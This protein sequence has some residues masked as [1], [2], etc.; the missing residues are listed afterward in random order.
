MHILPRVRILLLG[1][2]PS[3][4]KK[5]LVHIGRIAIEFWQL[6]WLQ[7]KLVKFSFSKIYEKDV[8]DTRVKFVVEG[9][10]EL[11]LEYSFLNQHL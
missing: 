8:A 10:R 4:C 6:L 2:W 9:L 3:L 1:V 5:D 11:Y 7:M